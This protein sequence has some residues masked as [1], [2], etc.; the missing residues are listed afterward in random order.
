MKLVIT[1]LVVLSVVASSYAQ[2]EIIVETLQPKVT[3]E[4]VQKAGASN[5]E[6]GENNNHLKLGCEDEIYLTSN[7]LFPDFHTAID[8]IYADG[9]LLDGLLTLQCETE[10]ILEVGFEVRLGAEL[11]AY[12]DICIP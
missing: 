2:G 6:I 8:L 11:D 5:F 9:I 7:F 10:I 12:I 1:S 4:H 3:V